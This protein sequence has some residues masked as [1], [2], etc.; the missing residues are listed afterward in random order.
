MRRHPVRYRR[1]LGQA[2][3]MLR[4]PMSAFG[5]SRTNRARSEMS[6]AGGRPDYRWHQSDLKR[7]FVR[8]GRIQVVTPRPNTPEGSSRIDYWERP[9]NVARC[10]FSAVACRVHPSPDRRLAAP[11]RFPLACRNGHLDDFPWHYFVHNGP[12]DCKGTLRFFDSGA[13]LQIENLWVK[14]DQCGDSRNMAH[15]FGK[16]GKDN[17][18]ACR[19]VTR[20]CINTSRA[21]GSKRGRCCW[22]RLTAGFPSRFQRSRF[23]SPAIPSPS[24]CRS[25]GTI[26]RTSTAKPKWR[27]APTIFLAKLQIARLP[28][29]P[30]M[31]D[32]NGDDALDGRS[33]KSFR[34]R[35]VS[36]WA[37][38]LS[39]DS[40]TSAPTS[41]E[42]S[43][44]AVLCAAEL[45]EVAGARHVRLYCEWLS[46]AEGRDPAEIAEAI[47]EAAENNFRTCTARLLEKHQ[48][49]TGAA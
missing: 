37:A 17:L 45:V 43:R 42:R 44:I 19:A 41:P 24:S 40:S 49:L 20:T 15:A 46:G 48:A 9:T 27:L 11:P 21:V 35:G 7:R 4:E 33:G 3:E 29:R 12:S 30:A 26:S 36:R 13:S 34:T 32:G 38:A 1:L 10:C 25:A 6:A 39:P 23:H 5:T 31:L 14:C 28:E 2:R 8:Y 47:I 22:G 18:P 16:A